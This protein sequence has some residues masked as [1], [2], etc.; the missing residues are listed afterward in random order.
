[1][2][3]AAGLEVPRKVWCHGWINVQG[4]RFSK[5][6]GVAVSLPSILDRYGADALRY[7]VVREVPWNADG[8]FSWERFEVRY[9][10]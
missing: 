6:A 2:L 1:M 9:T 7:F 8:N 3:M 5:S 4:A 10:A